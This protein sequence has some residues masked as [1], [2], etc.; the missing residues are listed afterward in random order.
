[1]MPGTNTFSFGTA[2]CNLH[3][4]HCQNADISQNPIEVT[5]YIDLPPKKAVDGAI[6][7]DCPSI[8][9]TYN[10]PIVFIE[11]AMDTAKLAR[12]K[13][14]K[15]I[16]VTNG[17]INQKPLKDLCKRIDA[18]HVDL[19]CFDDKFYREI[20]AARLEP[21]LETMKTMRK[22]GV[23]FEVINLIIPTLNDDFKKIEEMCIW[24]S[25]NLG[26]Y[27]P[28][29]FSRFFP[30]YKL[31]NLHPTPVETLKKAKEIA[32]K[33]LDYVYIG[34]IE[35]E[36]GENT[37]CPECKTLLIERTP[38]YGLYN[39][40]I[41]KPKSALN[42]ANEQK[43]VNGLMKGSKTKVPFGFCPECKHKIHGVF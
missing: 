32:D 40:K 14:L 43:K 19:K 35:T 24:I 3:C 38:L 16:F 42:P 18:A 10:D 15:N 25:E 5:G 4:K 26:R 8:S 12:K 39:N 29:H 31:A 13:G 7:Q 41:V 37:Y 33:Y 28:L 23:W 20:S 9:Y 34:N 6:S 30:C 36:N 27:T 2:G 11:Y 21:V 22:E 1:F 17:Y